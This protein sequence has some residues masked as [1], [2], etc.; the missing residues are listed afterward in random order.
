MLLPRFLKPILFQGVGRTKA[1]FEGWYFKQSLFDKKNHTQRT[2]AI[3]PGISWDANGA[4]HAFIQ[5]I[6]SKDGSSTYFRFPIQAFS[7]QDKP[8]SIHIEKNSFSTEGL[9]VDLQDD[10]LSIVADLSFHQLTPIKNIMGPYKYVPFM[11]CNHGI[12]SMYHEVRGHITLVR[13][14]QE[15]DRL[16]LAPGIGYIEKDWGRSMPSSWIW[17]NAINFEGTAGP[18]SF[19]FSLAKVPWQ[20]RHF[21]GFITVLYVNG[22]EYRFATYRKGHIDLLEYQGGILRILLSDNRYK[23]EIL[24]RTSEA[25]ELLAPVQGTMD[26]RIGECNNAWVRVVIKA[27]HK[28]TDAPLFDGIATGSGVELVGDI[29]RLAIS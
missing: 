9:H 18:V 20:S 14:N 28:M 16:T 17:I 19:F 1:Y 27:K 10:R 15:G 25:G 29:E 12:I 3:I 6:D 21:N 26:R 23:V 11:E 13:E 24:V 22:R 4:G 7:F 5:T 8:F 2:I